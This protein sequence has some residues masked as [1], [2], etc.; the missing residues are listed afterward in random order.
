M[1]CSAGS[2]SLKKAGI[3]ILSNGKLLRQLIRTGAE[4]DLDAFRG[5]AKQVI[6]E[7]RQ[8]QH[9]E[10][11][12]VVNAVLQMLDAYEDRSLIIAATNHE[13]MLYSAIWRRFEEVLVLKPPTVAQRRRLLSLKRRGVRREFAIDDV[14][15]RGWF[16]GATHADVERVLGRALKEMV[17]QGSA[18]CGCV[19]NT[20]KRQSA[21]R[22]REGIE[23]GRA[24][25]FPWP[26]WR[27][28]GRIWS[29]G[30]KNLSSSTGHGVDSLV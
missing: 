16:K 27:T 1:Y 17:L 2:R 5:V 22:T 19:S 23:Q 24:E 12:R 15:G 11:R 9:G 20:W 6:A 21:A 7:E 26:K 14:V 4:G 28:A 30:G 18:I 25:P 29:C 10:L 8:K 3:Q 13:G